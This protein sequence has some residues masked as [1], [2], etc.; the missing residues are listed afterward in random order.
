M[1]RESEHD[2]SGNFHDL[3]RER[4]TWRVAQ[5]RKASHRLEQIP[6]GRTATGE[7]AR[8]VGMVGTAV[9]RMRYR[10]TSAGLQ[11]LSP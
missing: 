11:A 7:I 4:L 1:E 5:K 9:P 8:M 6:D 2:R 10:L 3:P